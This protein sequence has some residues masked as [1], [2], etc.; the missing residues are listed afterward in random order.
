MVETER[1]AGLIQSS[2]MHE[3]TPGILSVACA[4]QVDHP[5]RCCLT[6]LMYLQTLSQPEKRMKKTGQYSRMLVNI[7]C[8]PTTK[9]TCFEDRD[10]IAHWTMAV[11]CGTRTKLAVFAYWLLPP[12]MHI[13]R[14][15]H[16]AGT[17]SSLPA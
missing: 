6:G 11:C 4:S 16:V 3:M 14:H 8:A 15:S 12:P 10:E 2:F 13:G 17:P 7:D 1:A 5:A 9:S